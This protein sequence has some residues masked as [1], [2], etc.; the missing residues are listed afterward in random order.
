MPLKLFF[1]CIHT[2]EYLLIPSF[3]L[4]QHNKENDLCRECNFKTRCIKLMQ[5]W[6]LWCFLSKRWQC[7]QLSLLDQKYPSN[8]KMVPLVEGVLL[9]CA[10]RIVWVSRMIN[11]VLKGSKGKSWRTLPPNS[12]WEQSPPQRGTTQDLYKGRRRLLL[13]FSST[14]TRMTLSLSFSLCLS[15]QQTFTLCGISVD[16]PWEM[17]IPLGIPRFKLTCGRV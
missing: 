3:I 6:D 15:H 2:Q 16:V 13:I 5:L 11:V 1:S 12:A 9:L 4:T 14:H 8:Q 7:W 10:R 17:S